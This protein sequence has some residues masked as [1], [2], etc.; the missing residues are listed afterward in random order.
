MKILTIL[1]LSNEINGVLL[2]NGVFVLLIRMYKD[3]F[4]A[5]SMEVSDVKIL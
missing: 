1:S 5:F 3:T 4:T 2:Q